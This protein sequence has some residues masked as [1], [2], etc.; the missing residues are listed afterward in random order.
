MTQPQT[1][2]YSMDY[3]A[4]LWVTYD[5]PA[6]EAINVLRSHSQELNDMLTNSL[7]WTWTNTWQTNQNTVR[8]VIYI[9]FTQEQLAWMLLK[10][11]KNKR[12]IEV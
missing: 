8:L 3:P 5:N 7:T 6:R 1:L 2:S 10:Y 11:P 4:E 12:V 9:E